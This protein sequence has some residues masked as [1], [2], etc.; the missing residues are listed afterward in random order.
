[1]TIWIAI[2]KHSAWHVAHRKDRVDDTGKV[3][4]FYHVTACKGQQLS[5]PN[6]LIRYGEKAPGSTCKKCGAIPCNVHK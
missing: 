6:S 4:G 3:L 2:D 5:G 1:M